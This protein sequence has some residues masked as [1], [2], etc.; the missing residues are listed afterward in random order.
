MVG[1]LSTHHAHPHTKFL[2]MPPRTIESAHV[3]KRKPHESERK[4]SGISRRRRGGACLLLR[5]GG[6]MLR[7]GLLPS[8]CSAAGLWR[9]VR[10][11][12]G[13][14]AAGLCPRHSGR[15]RL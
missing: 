14:A 4:A 2:T 10:E 11:G 1:L 7:Y 5:L 6:W 9:S 8:C 15:V 12:A 13:P 3:T